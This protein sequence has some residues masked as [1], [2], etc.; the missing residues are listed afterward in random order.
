MTRPF[1][2]DLRERAV[3]LAEAGQ[4]IR[5]IGG[6]LRISPSCV[7]KWRKLKRETGGLKSGKIGG[8]KRRVLS[9]KW[10]VWL[11]RRVGS[12]RRFT[13]RGLAAELAAQG[14]KTDSRAVWVF[15]HAEGLSFK[16]K[17]AGDGTRPPRR[18]A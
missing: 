14:V 1:S 4:T 18:R 9:G 7:S 5:A 6:A 10:A 11:R 16:K 13:L 3:A 8:H 12:G 2:E 17:R 15:L